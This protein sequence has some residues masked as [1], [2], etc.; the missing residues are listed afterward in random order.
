MKGYTSAYR[1]MKWD[2][3]AN[4]LTTN[5]SYACSD[6]KLHPRRNRDCHYTKQ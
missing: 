1:R 3:P 6:N 2:Y 4:T 5:L